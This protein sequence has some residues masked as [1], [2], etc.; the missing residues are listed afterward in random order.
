MTR[1]VAVAL[2][3]LLTGCASAGQVKGDVWTVLSPAEQ[4]EAQA[5][6]AATAKLAEA[7][8]RT[9]TDTICRSPGIYVHRNGMWPTYNRQGHLISLPR[10]VLRPAWR[11]VVA[12]ELAHAWFSNARDDCQ[13]T[14][15][16]AR[17]ERNANHHAVEILEIGFG[18]D[19]A[20]AFRMVSS[21]LTC[22]VGVHQWD[23][24]CVRALTDGEPR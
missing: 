12:H 11:G 14:A 22:V 10:F 5:I 21:M 2:A 9:H 7:C 19:R 16:K 20:T 15:K 17:C 3:V 4:A 18:Y 24:E 1:W 8:L 23:Q 6:E 13:G